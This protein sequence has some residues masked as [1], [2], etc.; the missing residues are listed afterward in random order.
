[1]AQAVCLDDQQGGRA[2]ILSVDTLGFDAS[3]ARSVRESLAEKTRI[4]PDRII[5][6][7][8]HTHCAPQI[9]TDE[10]F[11]VIEPCDG[12]YRDWLKQSL[13]T[14]G[15]QAA[16]Q[17]APC[18]P[19]YAVG[20]NRHATYRRFW[21]GDRWLN[22]PNFAQEPERHLPIMEFCCANGK[23]FLIAVIAG[24]P[25]TAA[26]PLYDSHYQGALRKAFLDAHGIQL[27]ILSGAG[28][29]SKM[30][31]PLPDGSG[32]LANPETDISAI[33]KQLENDLQSARRDLTPMAEWR[34][35]SASAHAPL[36]VWIRPTSDLSPQ[37]ARARRD[38]AVKKAAWRDLEAGCR[39]MEILVISWNAACRWVFL[40]GEV[41]GGYGP[42]LRGV[43]STGE[44]AV[45]AYSQGLLHYI[46]TEQI[47][48]EGGYEG[49]SSFSNVKPGE[50]LL[51]C[52]PA[53]Q[54]EIVR[55]VANLKLQLEATL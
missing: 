12:E 18:I 10:I 38:N 2:L 32:W 33:A 45:V 20:I 46:P 42:L 9:R 30:T 1:M 27:V 6:N 3:W 55:C 54:S 21:T 50:T 53:T 49:N 28:A 14:M 40:E 34:I 13:V 15:T 47:A 29:D 22:A 8:S 51:P 37:E 52:H 17:C 4:A 48:L 44:T 36:P 16:Q 19:K 43:F 26:D 24:H 5:L 11:G 35:H 23:I 31:S 25:T 7:A 41:C 39:R